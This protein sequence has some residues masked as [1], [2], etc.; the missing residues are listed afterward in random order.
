[1]A[2]DEQVDSSAS[3]SGASVKGDRQRMEILRAAALLFAE[4]GFHGTRMHHIAEAVKLSRTA[5]YFYF[6][7]K[8]ELLASLVDDVTYTLQRRSA[9]L[10]EQ[11]H[12]PARQILFELVQNYAQLIMEL[13]VEFQF[14]S[15]TEADFPSDIAEAHDK[16][17]RAV[18][19]SFTRVISRGCREGAFVVGDPTIVSLAIIGMCNW[20]A[21]WFREAG[22]LKPEQVGQA[23]AELALQMVGVKT[24]TDQ[25]NEHMQLE[26][27]EI[28][29]RLVRLE[30]R[31]GL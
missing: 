26:I 28:K 11:E 10:V 22:R 7:N 3:S 19:Q 2:L 20:S 21:W 27:E 8:E 1:M 13:G 24:T 15:R 12:K 16:A 6:K 9:G 17:K 31:S 30:A 29:K 4:K 25:S 14:V 18:L 5:V 23:F